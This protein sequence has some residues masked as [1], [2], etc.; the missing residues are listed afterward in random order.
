[1]KHDVLFIKLSSQLCQKVG[2]LFVVG[3]A[4]IILEALKRAKAMGCSVGV[5]A[6]TTVGEETTGRGSYWVGSAIRPDV[7]IV[8]DVTFASDYPGVDAKQSGEVKLGCGGVL[9]NSSIGSRKVNDL[10]KA[11]AKEHNI[12]Y[13]IESYMGRTY[14]DADNLHVTGTGV[15]TALLSLPL[16][17]MH[18]PCEVCHMD[19]IEN[20][21]ELLAQF[22]CRIDEHIDLDP[23][24]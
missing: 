10:M 6:A 1:M 8:T 4:Y 16:R 13:Q 21:I 23:F 2:G 9:C 19:D 18:C 20:C 17:Y 3:C 12:P 15:V 5:Y 14:T 24:H 22:L 7:A 11:V